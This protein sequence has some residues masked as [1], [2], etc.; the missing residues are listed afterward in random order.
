[1]QTNRREGRTEKLT[2][3]HTTLFEATGRIGSHPTPPSRVE[4]HSMYRTVSPE[5]DSMVYLYRRGRREKVEGEMEMDLRCCICM[6]KRGKKGGAS[7]FNK[8]STE[9]KYGNGGIWK[10]LKKLELEWE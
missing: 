1:M 5:E 2:G 4:M 7:A 3:L 9:A 8:Y 6:M 10:V